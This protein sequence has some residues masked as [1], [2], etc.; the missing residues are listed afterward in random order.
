[1]R[2][3]RLMAAFGLDRRE[4][5]RIRKTAL[6]SSVSAADWSLLELIPEAALAVDDDGVVTGANDPAAAMFAR[7]KQ[8]L[9]GAPALDLFV[10][11]GPKDES[12]RGFSRKRARQQLRARRPDG[13]TFPIEASL[14]QVKGPWGL[15]TIAVFRDT[16]AMVKADALKTA[17][18][19]ILEMIAAG[20]PLDE[21]LKTLALTIESAS[22][23]MLVSILLTEPDGRSLRY[24]A[25]PSLPAAYVDA[26]STIPIGPDVGSC[27]TAAF[28]K[29]MV[30]ARDIATDPRW[31]NGKDIALSN[32]LRACWSNPIGAGDGSVLGTFALYYSEPRSPNDDDLTLV[33]RATHLAGIAIER[34]RAERVRRTTEG[35]YR[36]LSELTSDFA[37][38]F[39]FHD[40]GTAKVDWITEAF[41]RITGYDREE[42]ENRGAWRGVIHPDDLLKFEQ[43]LPRLM[44]GEEVSSEFRII[45]KSGDVRWLSVF[46]RP[47]WDDA[48]RHVV[49]VVGA[50][51]DFTKRKEAEDA[52]TMFL[53]TASHEL[54]T[55]LTVIHGF[56]Q[57]MGKTDVGTSEAE[58]EAA[59]A[60]E[61][62]A[63]Q[64]NTI[65][66]RILLSSRI[67]TGR[68]QVTLG[69]VDLDVLLDDSVTALRAATK[70]DVT[71]ART[72]LPPA[73][74]D[75][76]ATT[77]VID[78]LLDNAVK[79]SP[80][81]GPIQVST[82][83]EES[84]IWVDVRDN[85]IGMTPEQAARCFEKFWQ[86]ESSDV[87]R[88]GGTG[89]GL[90][91]VRS[92]VEAMGGEVTIDSA[93][94]EGSTFSFSV[95]RATGDGS[96]ETEG[97]REP[98]RGARTSIQE[99]MR[100]I[101]VPGGGK[102]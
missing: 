94:G 47:I 87:R 93:A 56:A 15:S 6:S 80:D 64:L 14:K 39:S 60:I 44:R 63:R 43:R 3:S 71:F 54:K 45:T 10:D 65:L 38:A 18:K 26:T 21:V 98:G 5:A 53:A 46:S 97:A 74:A 96:N 89:I 12:A 62:R 83:V 37:Y 69:E 13:S 59:D 75:A 23:N 99:F 20:R 101:G 1:M 16:S 24:G 7:A 22:D 51:Q 58:R 25:A 91:I 48:R 70:R 84:R 8:E 72:E 100:Q 40:D 61:R 67:E 4:R 30:V 88:F 2:S 9:I 81:G 77:T 79:Y 52:K 31:K 32:G 49:G 35:R 68:T 95:Q 55:P 50:A 76:N 36:T 29:Q 73:W 86:A 85:G 82:R 66:D 90:F 78:H 19:I 92:L 27:G 33:Q 102:S 41:T 42:W 34:D 17:E 11:A 28:T 57:L